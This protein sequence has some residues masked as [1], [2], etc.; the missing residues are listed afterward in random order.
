MATTINP[1]DQTITQHAIQIGAANNLLSSVSLGSTGQVLQAT[2]SN[3]PAWSTATYPSTTTANQLLVSTSTNIVGGL[4]AGTTGQLL[5][6]ITGSVP[7]FSSSTTG[8]YT[9]T[10]SVAGTA[11]LLTLSQTDNTNTSS[12]AGVMLQSGG[13]SGG[14]SYVRVAQGTARCY[15]FGINHSDSTLKINTGAN[16]TNLP[17]TGTNIWTMTS[18]GSNTKPKQPAANAYVHTPITNATG[19]GTAYGPVIFDVAGFDQ[20]SNY[21]TGT[22]LFT[23]PVA[24]IYRVTVNITF[25]GLGALFTSGEIQIKQGSNTITRKEFNPGVG[26]FGS[27]YSANDQF[28]LN[29]SANDTISITVIVSGSTKTI[30]IKADSFG[31]YSY[32]SFQLEC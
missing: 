31:Q 29:C 5:N 22:G 16:A 1:S 4:T 25:T 32:V 26:D 13:T 10:Q 12:H 28:L 17:S 11:E 24:G 21:G 14:D 23:C 30:G 2:S 19:D 9:F 15:S 6:G 8:N 18:A 27:D 3:D 20:Q 7:S